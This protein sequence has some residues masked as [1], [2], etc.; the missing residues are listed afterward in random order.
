MKTRNEKML[1]KILRGSVHRQ[2]KKCGKSNCKCFSGELHGPYFYHFIRSNGKLKKRYLK[3]EE[4]EQTRLA[5]LA[6]QNIEK[7]ER[8]NSQA[9]WQR[10]RE[11]RAEIRSFTNHLSY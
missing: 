10:L 1:P 11:I 8:D 7:S 2:F 4:V 5:C 9:V 6:R 3:A